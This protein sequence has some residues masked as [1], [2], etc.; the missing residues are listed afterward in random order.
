MVLTV[1]GFVGDEVSVRPGQYRNEEGAGVIV[2]AHVSRTLRRQMLHT[3]LWS[4]CLMEIN[5]LGYLDV[6]MRIIL[7]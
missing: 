6:D 4:E 5:H 3:K 2:V 1:S 7:R